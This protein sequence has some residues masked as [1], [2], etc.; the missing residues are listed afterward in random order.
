MGS[1]ALVLVVDDDDAMREMVVSLL[2]EEGFDVISAV[3]ADGALDALRGR[4]VE[5]VLSD[6]RMPGKSGFELL[7]EARRVAP[8]TPVILMTSFGGV[9]TARRAKREGAF[10]CL[11]KPFGREELLEALARAL[12]ARGARASERSEPWRRGAS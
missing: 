3:G 10:D 9:M 7:R 4:I 11:S 2:R 1:Y 12:L 5:V 6:I 8:G